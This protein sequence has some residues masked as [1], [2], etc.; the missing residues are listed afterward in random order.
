MKSITFTSIFLLVGLVLA[1]CN[2]PGPSVQDP[3]A[4]S[5]YAAQTVQAVLSP[6]GT[7]SVP[8]EPLATQALGTQTI[9]VTP[10]PT[11][12]CEDSAKYTDWTRDTVSY[13]AKEAAKP[14]APNKTFTMSWTFQNTGTCTWNS[15]YQMYFDSGTSLTKAVNFPI[16]PNGETV[17]PAGTVTVNIV[18]SAPAA[19]GDYQS[20]FRLQNDRGEAVMN[21]GVM[22]KVGSASPQSLARPG[23]LRYTYDCTSGSVS[24][25]LFW[26]DVAKDED[27]YR[28]YRDGTKIAELA[29]GV[30][31][32]NE[33]VPGT[34]K[35][36]YTVAAFNA[37]GES[38][39]KVVVNTS[40]CQ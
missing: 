13:D 10:T 6:A 33:I 34:G 35:Y 11:A 9:S 24:I 22:T 20:V 18:M 4:L 3:G 26:V 12:S 30:T 31:S 17:K 38:P 21:L 19:A 40:N 8:A 16:L 37:S 2:M 32:Y 36:N 29:S 39:A 15:T 27:G 28:I 7:Q 5:T 14:L 1:S 25:S 23:D